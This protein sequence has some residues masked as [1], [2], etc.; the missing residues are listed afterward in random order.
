LFHALRLL[1]GGA[2]VTQAAF[3]V[4]YGTVSAFSQAFSR[5]FG[6]PPS[7]RGRSAALSS[8]R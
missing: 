7:R 1:E 8:P 5:Q 6:V 3:D 4:G 2:S